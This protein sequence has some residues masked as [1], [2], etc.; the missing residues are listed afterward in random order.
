MSTATM[1]RRTRALLPTILIAGAVV[2][3]FILFTSI[4]TDRLWYHSVG[5]ES[6]FATQLWTRVGLFLVSGLVAA[7]VIGG[8]AALAQRLRPPTRS[9]PMASPLLE[10]YH[11][12][13]QSR[14]RRTVLATAVPA[15]IIGGT[16][17]LAETFTFLAWR[18]GTEFGVAD[19]RFGLDASFYVFALPWWKFVAGFMFWLLFFT[20]VV[21]ALVHYLFGGLQGRSATKAATAHI[22]ILA[23]LTLLV[24]GVRLWLDRYGLMI[25]DAPLLTGLTYTDSQVRVSGLTIMAAIAMISALLFLANVWLRRWSLPVV[26]VVLMLLSGLVIGMIYPAIIQAI[27]VNPDEPDTER[28]YIEDHLKATKSAFGITDVEIENYEAV[29]DTEPGQ[30]RADAEALPG[31]RLIDPALIGP[32]F[33]Q[34]QQVRGYYSFPKVLDVDRYTIDGQQTD[35]VVAARE[36]DIEGL[37]SQSWNNIR[38]VYTHGF[39]LVAAYGNRRQPQGDPEWMARDI[40]PTGALSEHEPRIY[41]GELHSD[42]SI[43]G[44]PAGT[45]PVELDTPGGGESDEPTLTTYTGDG[46]V[47][48]GNFF[49]KLLYAV[50]FADVNI[51]LSDRVNT[52]SKII[53]DRTPRLRVAQAAPFLQV[54]SNAYPAIVEGRLVWIVDAYTTSNSYPNSHRVSLEQATSDSMTRQAMVAQP[55][56]MVNYMRNSVKATVDAYDGTVTMYA[57]DEDD[58]VLKTWRKVFPDTVKDRS[59]ISD[60]LLSHLRYPEDMFKVQREVLGRYHVSDPHLWYQQTDLWVTPNDP[61]AGT[62]SKET[63]YYLSIRWPGDDEP[64]FSQTTVY[65]PNNRSNLASFMAVNADASRDDYGKIRILRMSGQQQIDG[66]GQT[67]NA[68]TTDPVVAETLRPLLNQGAASAEYGNLLT[69]PVGGGLLY[70]MPIYAQRQAST[71][72]Y[73]ALRFVVVRF[74]EKVAIGNTLQEALDK[75]FEGDSGAET[76][77]DPDAIDEEPPADEQPGQTDPGEGT[78]DEA[79]ARRALTEAEQAFNDAEKALKDGDLGTY[80]EKNAEAR[81]ALRRALQAMGR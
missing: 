58:P 28:P 52:E 37:Q 2:L 57:W 63:P 23:G 30:L 7:A 54:D 70:V 5:Y 36:M 46:G 21:T 35:A 40:P 50:K 76:G 10:R 59:E 74:G 33:E 62:G 73:P 16:A 22:S 26:S 79:A 43:V 66:P 38:T 60:D 68:M 13:L 80:Q 72:S 17:G 4:W 55:D 65:V 27:Q 31:I 24:H 15:L 51:M 81:A 41:F 8:N 77:E 20:T 25:D 34:L 71:G 67:F 12:M 39:G 53:Y 14:L 9:G 32:A 69:L 11:S 47:P 3:A 48:V 18:N 1:P 19:P 61:V 45:P 64:V 44:A 49:N 42:Y 75:V 6:V 29:T 56:R 78:A